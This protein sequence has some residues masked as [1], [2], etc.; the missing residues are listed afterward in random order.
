[1]RTSKEQ[2]IG[3]IDEALHDYILDACSAD[4]AAAVEAYKAAKGHGKKKAKQAIV[5][6]MGMDD[7]L[8]NAD[9]VVIPI[10]NGIGIIRIKK[11]LSCLLEARDKF[12]RLPV[13]VFRA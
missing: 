7:R 12:E 13:G 10:L 8:C 9:S 4:L 3:A 11:T 6:V 2:F 5:K 1:M